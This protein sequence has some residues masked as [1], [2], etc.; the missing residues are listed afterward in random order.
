MLQPK[1]EEK[2]RQRFIGVAPLGSHKDANRLMFKDYC[3]PNQVKTYHI[4]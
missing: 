2:N 1:I 4:D 3:H